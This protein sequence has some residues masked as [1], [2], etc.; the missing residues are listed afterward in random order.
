MSVLP[1]LLSADEAV[2]AGDYNMFV[3]NMYS[4]TF[5]HEKSEDATEQGLVISK[6]L[7]INWKLMKNLQGLMEINN[8]LVVEK[9]ALAKR[10]GSFFNNELTPSRK[11]ARTDGKDGKGKDDDRKK[12]LDSRKIAKTSDLS[13][14]VMAMANSTSS[15]VNGESSS[16][17]DGKDDGKDGEGNDLVNDDDDPPT[18]LDEPNDGEEGKSVPLS[19]RHNGRAQEAWKRS[20][21]GGSLQIKDN[22]YIRTMVYENC[23]YTPLTDIVEL[24]RSNVRS[25]TSMVSHYIEKNKSCL[26]VRIT[27]LNSYF[28]LVIP[29]HTV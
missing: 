18:D 4:V 9:D 3:D 6:L 1:L 17:S 2:T 29:L 27:I 10:G 22:H 25:T 15:S 8:A 28:V 5:L 16:S 23:L 14:M 24:V 26:K 21:F 7:S 20:E 19:V 13:S 12:K 11:R